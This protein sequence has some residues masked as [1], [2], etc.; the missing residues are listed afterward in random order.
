MP[1]A[2]GWGRG[3][4]HVQ[5]QQAGGAEQRLDDNRQVYGARKVHWSCLITSYLHLFGK[6]QPV[7]VLANSLVVRLPVAV[8][9]AGSS[10]PP[11]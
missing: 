8:T 3:D 9:D 4:P 1:G 11:A 2:F 5:R 7:V 10:H 6:A